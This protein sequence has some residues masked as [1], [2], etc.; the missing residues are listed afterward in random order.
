[1]ADVA[2]VQAADFGKLHDPPC[3]EDLNRPEIGRVLVEREVCE[4]LMVVGEVA[5]QDAVEV[6]LAEGE[7]LIQALVPDR[8][9]SRSAKGFCQGLRGAV[10]TSWIPCP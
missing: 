3:R 5:G 6:S 1:M 7:H 2:V 8:P 4:R 10:R 9:M